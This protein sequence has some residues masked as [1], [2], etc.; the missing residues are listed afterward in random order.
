MLR[1]LYRPN[2]TITLKELTNEF[3]ITTSNL[4]KDTSYRRSYTTL[5]ITKDTEP[6][7][8]LS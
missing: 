4:P 6:L 2:L 7:A 3:S 1:D 5:G 8:N